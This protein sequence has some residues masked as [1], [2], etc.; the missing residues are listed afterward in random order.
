MTTPI[1]PL[2]RTQIVNAGG[3]TIASVF[4]L[5]YHLSG[6]V[7]SGLDVHTLF[8]ST[9][10]FRSTTRRRF[11]LNPE[12]QLRGGADHP[13]GLSLSIAKTKLHAVRPSVYSPKHPHLVARNVVRPGSSK[14]RS[15]SSS[16]VLS[17]T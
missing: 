11:H 12:I 13:R 8:T 17:A 5:W 14:V 9:T 10:S 6:A 3:R 16:S 7:K 1:H 2:A 4:N 15:F